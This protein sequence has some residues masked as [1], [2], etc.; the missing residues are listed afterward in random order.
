MATTTSNLNHKHYKLKTQTMKKARLIKASLELLK[1]KGL[2]IDTTKTSDVLKLLI[3]RQTLL[4]SLSDLSEETQE[5][6]YAINNPPDYVNKHLKETLPGIVNSGFKVNPTNRV[7]YTDFKISFNRDL[8]ESELK[9][10]NDLA[11][12]L[13]VEVTYISA[14]EVNF[15]TR[16][17]Y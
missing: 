12:E 8:T 4:I 7:D 2:Q 11:I 10:V 13:D 3:K 5:V 6:I 16:N 14:N 9:S 17:S 15:C 1:K